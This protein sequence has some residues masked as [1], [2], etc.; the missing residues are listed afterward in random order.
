[1]RFSSKVDLINEVRR[2]GLFSMLETIEKTRVLGVEIKV[3]LK[4]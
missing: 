1:M 4:A 3:L 2:E